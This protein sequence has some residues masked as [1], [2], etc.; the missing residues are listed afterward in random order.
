MGPAILGGTFS[1]G[2]KKGYMI[3]PWWTLAFM[4]SLSALPVFWA[5]ENDQFSQGV[6][7][8]DDNNGFTNAN[9]NE[10]A[11]GEVP[12]GQD[13][14]DGETEGEEEREAMKEGTALGDGFDGANRQDDDIGSEGRSGRENRQEDG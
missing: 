6:D 14:S 12:G 1:L 9:G 11:R 5:K 7:D 8:D 2:V 10:E 13:G 4:A 3:L